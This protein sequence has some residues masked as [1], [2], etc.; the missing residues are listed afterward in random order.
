MTDAAAVAQQRG[1]SQDSH[2]EI[3][4]LHERNQLLEKTLAEK[5][6]IISHQKAV[7]LFI[8][9]ELCVVERRI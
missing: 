3:E 1:R 9:D 2:A 8:R 5:E 6:R 7:L 4:R